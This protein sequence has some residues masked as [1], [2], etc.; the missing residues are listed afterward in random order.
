MGVSASKLILISCI[1][2]QTVL[3]ESVVLGDG[4]LEYNTIV[5][6]LS[7]FASDSAKNGPQR[8]VIEIFGSVWP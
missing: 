2:V 5:D 8:P 6:V 1:S 7:E 4:G 3:K